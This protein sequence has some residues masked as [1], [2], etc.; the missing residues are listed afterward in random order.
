MLVGMVS[1]SAHLKLVL[2]AVQYSQSYIETNIG[3]KISRKNVLDGI[4]ARRA[5]QVCMEYHSST[6][7]NDT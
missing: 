3:T 6:E 7:L 1:K 5:R 2:T 4:R